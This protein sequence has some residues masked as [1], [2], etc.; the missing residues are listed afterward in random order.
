MFQ[1]Y[2]QE[3]FEF[4]MA[5]R[6]NN[7]RDF[8]QG[9]RDWY[10]RA[11]RGPSLALAEALEPVVERIDEEIERRPAKVVSR[12]NRDIRFSKDKSRYR[13]YIWLSY[14][15]PSEQKSA[16]PGF[17][18]DVSDSGAS[19]GMGFYGDNRPLMNALR[20]RLL[21]EPEGFM[22]VWEPVRNE[23]IL[24]GTR[25]KRMEVPGEICDELAE[26]YPLKGFYV[27]K[28]VKDFG[29]IKSAYLA[30]EIKEGFEKLAPFY[31]YLMDIMPEPEPDETKVIDPWKDFTQYI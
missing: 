31:R 29:L 21:R 2:T 8:F 22:E 27:A 25:F 17:Y 28:D 18:F 12:I 11:V 7:N 10:L 1:G 24:Y 5:I 26:W 9:N 15:R 16:T 14:K 3:T 4:F 30:D 23:F 20:T 6:F 19:Y 13:D